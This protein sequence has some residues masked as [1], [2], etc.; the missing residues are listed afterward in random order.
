MPIMF[1]I[2]KFKSFLVA[3]SMIVMCVNSMCASAAV[4][5]VDSEAGRVQLKMDDGS[6]FDLTL[7]PEARGAFSA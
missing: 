3:G 2:N 7:L 6:V 5:W 4:S 1:W